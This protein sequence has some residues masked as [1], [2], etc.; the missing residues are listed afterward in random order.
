M[1]DWLLL[2]DVLLEFAI[3]LVLLYELKHPPKP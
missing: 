2:V 3:L 1:T